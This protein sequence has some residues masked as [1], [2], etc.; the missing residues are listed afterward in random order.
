[1]VRILNIAVN[2]TV[3]SSSPPSASVLSTQPRLNTH[4][5]AQ[6]QDLKLKLKSRG[7]QR[8]SFEASVRHTSL[9]RLQFSSAQELGSRHSGTLPCI[10]FNPSLSGITLLCVI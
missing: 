8:R 9:L 5:L 7:R 6:P 3:F 4:S 2:L 10:L 1:M